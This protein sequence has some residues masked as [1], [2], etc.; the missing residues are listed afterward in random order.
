MWNAN[1]ILREGPYFRDAFESRDWEPNQIESNGISMG[2][3]TP[4]EQ[5]P[6]DC[7]HPDVTLLISSEIRSTEP[8]LYASDSWAPHAEFITFLGVRS[9]IVD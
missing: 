9:T 7:L 4:I 6:I 1:R 3:R 8:I 5:T 2:I